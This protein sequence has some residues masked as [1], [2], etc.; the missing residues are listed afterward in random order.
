MIKTFLD[1]NANHFIRKMNLAFNTNSIALTLKGHKMK[2][3]QWYL[4][5][6]LK[7]N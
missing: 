7:V 1:S 6:V 5:A 3:V 4:V 2:Y